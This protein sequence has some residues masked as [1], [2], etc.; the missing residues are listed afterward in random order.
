MHSEAFFQ[1]RI[2]LMLQYWRS[3]EHLE[4]FAR[5]S[6][7][8]HLDAWR[9]WNRRLRDSGD[10]GIWHETYLVGPG[11]VESVY[12][13]MPLFGLAAAT[14]HVPV[15]RVGQTAGHRLDPARPDAVAVQP[16]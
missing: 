11:S 6:D 15:G 13:N 10:A 14:T 12:G 5:D 3:Y 2:T 8:P 4:R 7:L 1:G 9:R 16:Y